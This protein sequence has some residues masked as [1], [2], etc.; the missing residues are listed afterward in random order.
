[1]TRRG[2]QLLGC[3]LAALLL[4]LLA[5]A[6]P[7]RADDGDGDGV[8]DAASAESDPVAA[9]QAL[10]EKFAPVLMLVH[11]D[12][13]CGPGEPYSPSAVEV[14]FDNPTVALRGPWTQRDLVRV[15]PSAEE[16][17]AGLPGYELD[18]PG[19]PLAPGCDYEKWAER[20]WRGTKPTI[21]AHLATQKG[22]PDRIA[23]QYFFF[24]A[25]N[26]YNNKHETD[27]ERIQ[28][29]FAAPDAATALADGLVPEVAVYSQHY[30][31]E[32]ATWGADD[33]ARDDKLELDDDTHPV[34]YVSAGSHA[35]QF[36]AGVFM[37]NTAATGFGC[38]TTAGDHDAVR[39]EVRTIPSDPELARSAYPWIGYEGHYGEVGPKR[40]Y[41]GPTGPNRKQAWTRP[42]TWSG[43]ARD[44]SIEVPGGGA[45]STAVAETY[46]DLVGGGSDLFRRYVDDPGRGLVVLVAALLAAGWLVRRTSWAT[47]AL[48]L[49]VRR[50]S[51]QVVAAS[52]D[53]LRARP[54]LFALAMAPPAV[55]N[56][57]AAVLQGVTV[58]SAVPGWVGGAAVLLGTTALPVSAG[59]LAVVVR[60]LDEDGLDAPV[61]LRSAYATSLRRL[62]AG[63]PAML[64]TALLV[65]GLTTSV[66]L[67]PL[68]L[69]VLTAGVLLVPVVVLERRRGFAGLPRAVRLVRHSFGT[70]VPVL[71]LGLLLLTTVGAVVAA[72]LFVVV[73]VPFLV[74]NTVPSVV[75]GVVWP[76]VALMCVYAYATALARSAQPSQERAAVTSAATPDSSVAPASGA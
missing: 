44:S 20:Q 30:G 35:N 26:D 41:A 23:L 72:L 27:W 75:L 21:Y 52:L 59:A 17:S 25:F 38:D 1:M 36:S 16:V 62:A 61:A 45:S 63:L 42:F 76:F 6:P 70:L 55:L 33:D 5:S 54:G 34:V 69:V 73:P 19:N 53:V 3:L 13:A 32:R 39:A 11:Q 67:A 7:A 24:Y 43:K 4:A 74:L 60:V 15:G 51:G 37:G 40:F 47:T 58:A 48:P 50:S 14:L 65:I 12:H 31:A 22:V 56:V 2:R 10:A 29:E 46:C 9:E 68:A 66:V 64:V 57:L 18:L 28:L 49:R 8:E 71:A